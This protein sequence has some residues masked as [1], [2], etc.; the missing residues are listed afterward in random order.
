[1]MTTR[2][3]GWKDGN[4]FSFS[5]CRGLAFSAKCS[6]TASFLAW[7]DLPIQDRNGKRPTSPCQK[8]AEHKSPGKIQS[9]KQLHAMHASICLGK[10]RECEDF[11]WP[12]NNSDPFMQVW[13]SVN[14]CPHG[15][16]ICHLTMLSMLEGAVPL[17]KVFARSHFFVWHWEAILTLVQ[18]EEKTMHESCVKMWQP[19][20]RYGYT[21]CHGM[22]N[23]W[24]PFCCKD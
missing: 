7:F 15:P 14:T 8:H 19:A 6:I 13:S 17:L 16:H 12:E 23:G 5:F 1:M 11:V 22:D 18:K 10:L 9:A 20:E 2:D 21:H 24:V 4:P 3:W